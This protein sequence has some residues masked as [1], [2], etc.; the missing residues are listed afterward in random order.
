MGEGEEGEG[1]GGLRMLNHIENEKPA[2]EKRM[3]NREKQGNRETKRK[4]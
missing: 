1:V 3:V 2:K 4:Y